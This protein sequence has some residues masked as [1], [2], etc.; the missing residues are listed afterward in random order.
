[1][2][3]SIALRPSRKA[4]LWLP[5]GSGGRPTAARTASRSACRHAGEGEGELM[6]LSSALGS[7]SFFELAPDR[8]T[9]EGA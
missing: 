7:V 3:L 4:C 6:G 1:M 9:G 8:V 2:S 5:L